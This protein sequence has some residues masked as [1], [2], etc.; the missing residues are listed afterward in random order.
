MVFSVPMRCGLV[1]KY[2]RF[3]GAHCPPPN[4]VENGDQTFLENVPA[5]KP[6]RPKDIFSAVR[7]SN[8][9][10]EYSLSTERKRGKG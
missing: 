1:C 6:R 5:L 2:R 7:T 3:G 8:L 4:L 10:T 9:E